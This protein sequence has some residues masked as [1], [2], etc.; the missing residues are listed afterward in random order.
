MKKHIY[1]AALVGTGRIGF[2]LGFDK[3]REQPASHTMAVKKNK[4][5][6][7]IAGCDKDENILNQ[8]HKYNPKTEI[9]TDLSRLLANTKP[10]IFIIA[11]NED[12]HMETAIQ[13]IR[14][15]P[16]LVILEKPVALNIEQAMKIV[17]ESVKYNVPVMVNHERRFATDYNLAKS[18]MKLIGDL[19]SIHAVLSSGMK[20]YSSKD[21]DNGEYSL[22]HD[23]THLVD[24]IQFLLEKT[25]EN[26]GKPK[27]CILSNPV[28]SG[29]HIDK[30]DKNIIR[31]V[32]AHFS[33]PECSQITME[34][35]GRS[36]YFGFEIDI[37]GTEGRIKIGNGFA[38]VYLREESK[39]Y[40]GFYS[41]TEMKDIK[42]PTKTGYFS[43]MIQNA[44]DYLDG[45]SMLKSSLKNGLNAMYTL[46]EIKRA[47][48]KALPSS[49]TN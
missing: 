19:Q 37:R 45:K 27:E 47:M 15:K 34:F 28:I 31:N 20:V 26:G 49:K 25:P 43:N 2:T 10:D 29:I 14:S 13:I 32:S 3:K 36:K 8:W 35:S 5:I 39:L 1:T 33:C 48:L 41:L 44:V 24:I 21:E 11:V 12:A 23:G 30:G 9:F 17:D 18:Y 46:E 6:R 42:F 40:S 4:R 7:F 16:S 22:L 38:K